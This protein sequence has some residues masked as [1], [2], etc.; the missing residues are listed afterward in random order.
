MPGD[1]KILKIAL[2]GPPVVFFKDQVQTIKRKQTRSV[3]YYLACQKEPV[4]RES[5][6]SRFW[7]NLSEQ[8]SRKN[9]REIL[10]NLRAQFNGSEVI[11]ARY[12]QLS[13]NSA[14][15][16][17]DVLRFQNMVDRVHFNLFSLPSGKL[18]DSLYHEVREGVSLWRTPIFMEGFSQ[19]LPELENWIWET[20][21]SLQAWRQ[22]LV[23][24]LV[25]HNI[26]SGNLNEA[27]FWLADA[28]KTEPLKADLHYL[29]LTCLRD[30]GRISEIFK[31][32]AV[33]ERIYKTNY[34]MEVP[35][36]LL[37]FIERVADSQKPF[38]TQTSSA[39]PD[40]AIS[41]PPFVGRKEILQQL[42]DWSLQ[43]GI[44]I[45]RG[46]SGMGKTRTVQEFCARTDFPFRSLLCT[47]HPQEHH[48]LLQPF[49]EGLRQVV[50]KEEWLKLSPAHRKYLA[51]LFPEMQ[52]PTKKVKPQFRN[53]RQDH[54]PGVFEAILELLTIISQKKR[55]IVIFDN[56]Q[57]ADEASIS[58]LSFLAS[59]E[60]FNNHGILILAQRIGDRNPALEQFIS[61]FQANP[62]FHNLLLDV[63]NESEIKEL[64]S[65]IMGKVPPDD[66]VFR[67]QR[68][69]SGNPFFLLQTLKS[70]M[71]YSTNMDTLEK[72]PNF[73]IARE[74]LS[75]MKA[76][77][78]NLDETNRAVLEAAA[79]IGD[80]FS[81]ELL[82]EVTLMDPGVITR[83]LDDLVSVHVVK[84]DPEVKPAGGYVFSHAPILQAILV[85]LSPAR[86]RLLNKQV[87]DAMERLYGRLPS[88]AGQ[89]AHYYESAGEIKQAY[90]HWLQ[91]AFFA[92]E[93]CEKD[94]AYAAYKRAWA[95]LAQ[96]EEQ[97]DEHDIHDLVASWGNYAFDQTDLVTCEQLFQKCLELGE[98]RH[99]R[100]LLGTAHTGIARLMGI[101]H[102]LVTARKHLE[103]AFKDLLSGEPGA[104]LMN[105]YLIQGHL[106]L[107]ADNFSSAKENYEKASTLQLDQKDLQVS[108]TRSMAQASLSILYS[109]G[110]EPIKGDR[111]A[112]L[113]IEASRNLGCSGARIQ[114]SISKC[115]AQLYMANYRE[116]IE[117]SELVTQYLKEFNMTYWAVFFYSILSRCYLMVGQLDKA[118]QYMQKAMVMISDS[119][120]GGMRALIHGLKGDIYLVLDSLDE[121]ETEYEN[122]LEHQSSDFFALENACKLGFAKCLKGNVGSG[123]PQIED[124]LLKGKSQG[125]GMIT[126]PAEAVIL[127]LKQN[128]EDAHELQSAQ[129]LLAKEA[130]HRGLG[131]WRLVIQFSELGAS[132]TH[133]E[134]EHLVKRWQQLVREAFTISNTWLELT[135]HMQ[136]IQSRQVP[137]ELRQLSRRRI[138][139]I[140]DSL[141][142]NALSDPVKDL[143]AEYTGKIERKI[144]QT[145]A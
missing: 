78:E 14:I 74:A 143:V 119:T 104:E 13:L 19:K 20:G 62:N 23:E 21:N 93:R 48:L 50:Q 127:M 51:G 106:D 41:T 5:L 52:T 47:A 144:E 39:D 65:S 72:L 88:L 7:P 66:M 92:R 33:L 68:D 108:V 130:E 117:T 123:L 8:E 107:L 124:A 140:L 84:I 54:L 16:E 122:H 6:V 109:M 49:I 114:G 36:V 10:S 145:V 115:L 137:D 86:K 73:P 12:D 32:R 30:S 29:M 60:I 112:D 59:R 101:K 46:G 1:D 27:I 102:Q 4:S 134:P 94:D 96:N 97:F 61:H 9:L 95:L 40:L 44:V 43:G 11:I 138:A 99:N 64:T 129:E 120:F 70:T 125:L 58:L 139:A 67:L 34:S 142:E 37:D 91:S 128:A 90:E 35:Q 118:W 136:I 135:F 25:D 111:I 121:A 116:V 80:P 79:V 105:A 98:K 100:Y 76:R 83:I 113:S 75:L 71:D 38:V 89:Y 133:Q 45:L 132:T 53:L 42:K 24:R 77:L 85:N 81:P 110:G 55:L 63:L 28:L 103:Q 22:S 141:T 18:P 2:L 26:S 131:A 69:V 31:Y 3:L 56:A 126:L 15:T 17:V 82:E 57:W 87:I